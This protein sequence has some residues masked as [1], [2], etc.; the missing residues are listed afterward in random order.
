[1]V[2]PSSA[3]IVVPLSTAEGGSSRNLKGSSR[4]FVWAGNSSGRR[5]RAL[6]RPE[7]DA[8]VRGYGAIR[9]AE[10]REVACSLLTHSLRGHPYMMSVSEGEGYKEKMMK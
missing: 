9:V 6:V 5:A 8:G 10:C 7:S 1:M 2:A 3:G 4:N